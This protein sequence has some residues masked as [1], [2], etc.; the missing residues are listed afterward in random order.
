[1]L[2]GKE[3]KLSPIVGATLAV[4]QKGQVQDRS[5]EL[6]TKPAPTFMQITRNLRF[7]NPASRDKPVLSLTTEMSR[8][9]LFYA[10]EA[11]VIC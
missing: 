2:V 1:M 10:V 11:F 8:L 4:A 5:A 9:S 3:A 7:S 6:T